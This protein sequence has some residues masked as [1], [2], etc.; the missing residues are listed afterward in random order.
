MKH[1]IWP[2]LFFSY[3]GGPGRSR[4]KTAALI[5]WVAQAFNTRDM[6]ITLPHFGSSV[7][8]PLTYV[9]ETN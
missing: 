1:L 8:P 3:V 9:T 4:S 6:N 7:V 2:F 5:D